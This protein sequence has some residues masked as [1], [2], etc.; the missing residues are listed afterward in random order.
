MADDTL[1]TRA[2]GTDL[3]AR[4]KDFGALEAAAG[5][6]SKALTTGL[7]SAV[8]QGRSLDDTLKQVALRLSGAAL[9]ASLKPLVSLIENLA[10]SLA[11]TTGNLFGQLLGLTGFAKGGVVPFAS[12]GVVATPS[13]FPLGN[14]GL[15]VMGEAGA[16]A[17]LPLGR[18]ADGSLGVRGGGGSVNVTFNVTTPNADSFRQSEAQLGVMLARAVGRGRRG[19]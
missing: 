5:S 7:K 3:G 4:L 9:E 17:I 18:T 12:G 2:L 10:G 13:Y 8:L 15:G 16:E 6:F 1:N 11:G 14:G 19:L